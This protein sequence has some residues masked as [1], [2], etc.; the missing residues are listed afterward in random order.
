MEFYSR[1]A[2]RGSHRSFQATAGFF[3]RSRENRMLVQRVLINAGAGGNVRSWGEAEG[4]DGQTPLV[5]VETAS[6]IER[7]AWRLISLL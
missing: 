3:G 7:A 2:H 6:D 5:S 4:A 1:L